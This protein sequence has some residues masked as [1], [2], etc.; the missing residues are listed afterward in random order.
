MTEPQA[1]LSV[2]INPLKYLNNLPEFN[3]DY[4]DLQTFI[5]LIDRV[6]PILRAYDALSQQLFSDIIKSRLRGRAR[7]TIEIN[8]QAQSWSDIKTI[9]VNNFGDKHSVEE[10][11]DRLKGTTFKTNCVDFYNELKQSLRSLNN[12]TVTLVGPGP[13]TNECARNNMKTALNVFKEKL[14]EP[15]KTILICRNPDTLEEAIEILF[16][17]GHAYSRNRSGPFGVKDNRK[18]HHNQTSFHGQNQNQGR[19]QKSHNPRNNPLPVS[20]PQYN[21]RNNRHENFQQNGSNHRLPNVPYRPFNPQYQPPVEPMD[22]NM[23]QTNSSP[24]IQRQT[25]A[26]DRNRYLENFQSQASQGNYPI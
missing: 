9:L 12:K 16:Q 15:M 4:R 26:V 22:V 6:H 20:Q 23:I 5:N 24:N 17:S 7:E 25:N 19:N 21:Y 18:L 11:F 2:S 10:L 8:C 3:G 14:P 1:P 13:A